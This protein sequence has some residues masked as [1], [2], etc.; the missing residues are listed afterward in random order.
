M[1]I[2]KPATLGVVG[3]GLGA[4]GGVLLNNVVVTPI[5]KNASGLSNSTLSPTVSLS[6]ALPGVLMAILVL[7]IS[8]LAPARQASATKVMYAINPGAAEAIGLDEPG[9]VPRAARFG[10]PAYNWTGFG[11]RV[12][13]YLCRL[14][15]RL[16]LRRCV[17]VNHR[18]VSGTM[19]TMIVGVSMMFS[20]LAVPFERLLLTILGWITPK[21][22]FFVSRYVQ[23]GKERNSW[24]SLMIR[25]G[26]STAGLCSDDHRAD[27][28]EHS[29]FNTVAQRHTD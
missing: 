23:R 13:L 27:E 12:G 2:L 11:V 14:R 7:S 3:T 25:S 24:L 5:L 4:V 9:Q 22:A 8:A 26:S 19:L 28:C 1:V 17:G 29:N 6:T 18:H 10:Q 15:S 21:R 20:V 16:H